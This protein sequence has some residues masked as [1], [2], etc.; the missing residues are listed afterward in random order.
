MVVLMF[1]F[2]HGCS[3]DLL[4]PWISRTLTDE[5]IIEPAAREER[6]EKKATT[7]LETCSK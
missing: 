2:G 3:N 4:Y 6:L 1:A 7:W 5:R